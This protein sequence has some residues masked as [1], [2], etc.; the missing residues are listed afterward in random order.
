MVTLTHNRVT[1]SL[2]S[3]ACFTYALVLVA[4]VTAVVTDGHGTKNL[5]L[6]NLGECS[7]A[8]RSRCA[9]VCV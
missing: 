8:F 4:M 1:F 6:T 7:T 3:M 5:D 9:L 2:G